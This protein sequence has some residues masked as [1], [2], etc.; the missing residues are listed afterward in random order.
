MRLF[1]PEQFF[2]LVR[3]TW[4]L[5]GLFIF[6]ALLMGGVYIYKK[7]RKTMTEKENNNP[8]STPN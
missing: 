2:N 4:G 1:I 5:L 3:R 6:A 7:Q 8:P